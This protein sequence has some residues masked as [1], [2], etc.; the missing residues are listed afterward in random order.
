MTYKLIAGTN[1]QPIGLDYELLLLDEIFEKKQEEIRKK[2]KRKKQRK[3]GKT[4][5]ETKQVQ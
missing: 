3:D 2:K 1:G 5:R 4:D